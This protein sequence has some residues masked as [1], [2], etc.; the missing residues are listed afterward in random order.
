MTGVKHKKKKKLK[1]RNQDFGHGKIN[2]THGYPHHIKE[3]NRSCLD[4]KQQN[5]RGGRRAGGLSLEKVSMLKLCFGITLPVKNTQ[6]GKEE[7]LINGDLQAL[8][9]R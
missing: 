3:T 5:G 6:K 1:S 9:H 7:E 2:L 4:E 8:H